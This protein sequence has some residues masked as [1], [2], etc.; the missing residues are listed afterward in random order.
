LVITDRFVYIHIGKTGGTFV[1][2]VLDRLSGESREYFNTA[3]A[4]DRATLRSLDQHETAT[5]IPEAHRGRELLFTVRNP[6]DHYVSHYEYGVWKQLNRQLDFERTRSRYTAYPN[7]SFGDFLHAIND[8]EL[9]IPPG[10][11]R[12]RPWE[13]RLFFKVDIGFLTWNYLRFCFPD[14][15]KVVENLDLYMSSG[16]WRELVP[17]AHFLRTNCL[18]RDLYAFLLSVG[19]EQGKLDFILSM[20]RILPPGPVRNSSEEWRKHY[21]PN[22]RAFVRVK[23]RFVFAMFPEF[24]E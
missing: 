11:S 21:T 2:K 13:P 5:E 6:Y 10:A 20:D 18:N 8:W 24:D 9:R 1:E 7:L 15:I 14:P 23:E 12:S 4:S 22:L 3:N 16:K 19:Y 17:N